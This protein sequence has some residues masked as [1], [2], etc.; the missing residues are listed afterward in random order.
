MLSSLGGW[1]SQVCHNAFVEYK[2][3]MKRAVENT[4]KIYLCSIFTRTLENRPF[5]YRDFRAELM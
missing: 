1:L 2:R 5:W 3:A 4:M